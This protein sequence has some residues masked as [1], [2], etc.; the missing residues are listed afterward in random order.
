MLI[1]AA[2]S[3]SLNWEEIFDLSDEELMRQVRDHLG[4]GVVTAVAGSAKGIIA[5]H[6]IAELLD[7]QIHSVSLFKSKM[8]Q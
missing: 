4:I 3:A 7:I 6:R 5:K 1:S 2:A 8:R